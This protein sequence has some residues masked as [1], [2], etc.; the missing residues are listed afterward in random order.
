MHSICRIAAL[1]AAVLLVPVVQASST[2][3]Y[4]WVD[5]EGVTHYTQQPPPNSDA[6]LITPNTAGPAQRDSGQSSR[7][8]QQT[9]ASADGQESESNGKGEG[10]NAP[11]NM[12]EFCDQLR[13]RIA[14]L[15]SS[16]PVSVRQPDDTL[17]RLSDKERAQ[18]L[19]RARGQQ[20]QHCSDNSGSD[21]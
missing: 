15:E 20:Q 2:S 5:D 7:G 1:L 18:Q 19:E 14:T 17:K 4:K 13:E 3:I 21:G 8:A 10:G 6:Q 16:N 9:D 12:T 11:Q